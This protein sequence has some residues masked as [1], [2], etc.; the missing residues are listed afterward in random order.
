TRSGLFSRVAMS[1]TAGESALLE[2]ST[3]TNPN[4]YLPI[5]VSV[6]SVVVANKVYD[7]TTV[8]GL[9]GTASLIGVVSGDSVSLTGTPAA[10]FESKDAG[11][12][13]TV[14]V[15]GL[16][17]SGASASKYILNPVILSGNITPASLGVTG[18]SGASKMYDATT[19]AVVSG[20]PALVG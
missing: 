3:N 16:S 5:P 2:W 12:N 15:T 8:A 4:A 14:T 6:T 1:L 19:T 11:A 17:L 13:K 10:V 18:L 9:A 20:T 7:G